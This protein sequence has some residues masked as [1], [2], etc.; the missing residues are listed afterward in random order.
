MY[1]LEGVRH[2]VKTKSDLQ[3]RREKHLLPLL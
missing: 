2:G 1:A 3:K